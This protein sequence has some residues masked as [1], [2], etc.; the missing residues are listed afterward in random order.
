VAGS[1]EEGNENS[2]SPE[3]T[4]ILDQFSYYWVLKNYSALWIL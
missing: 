3:S 4:E 1:F 2:G